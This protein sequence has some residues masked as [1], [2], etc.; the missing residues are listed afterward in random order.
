MASQKEKFEIESNKEISRIKA[1]TSNEVAKFK[2]LADEK[3]NELKGFS[4]REKNYQVQLQKASAQIAGLNEQLIVKTKSADIAESQLKEHKDA[5]KQAQSQILNLNQKITEIQAHASEKIIES[6]TELENKTKEYADTIIKIKTDAMESLARQKEE[7]DSKSAAEISELKAGF[8]QE[9]K[10]YE[11][12]LEESEKTL[13]TEQNQKLELELKFKAA[14][15]K[16]SHFEK[17]LNTQAQSLT[18]LGNKYE[19]ERQLR[20]DTEHKLSQY[21]AEI[22]VQQERA[23]SEAKAKTE[24]QEN[25]QKLETEFETFKG[26]SEKTIET[27]KSEL[28]KSQ[29]EFESESKI[30]QMLNVQLQNE[31]KAKL[32]ADEELKKL[33]VQLNELKVNSANEISSIKTQAAE[34]T[35]KIKTELEEKSNAY[36]DSVIKANADA[37]QLLL[38]EKEKWENQTDSK[39]EQVKNQAYEDIDKIKADFENKANEYNSLIKEAEIKLIAETQSAQKPK[40]NCVILTPK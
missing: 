37:Q 28:D 4:E 24:I 12:L 19:T 25:L 20:L 5:L 16:N 22:Q 7:L 32:Q 3:A 11:L 40:K 17:Q 1:E 33:T 35:V 29:H 36:A 39:I 31:Q 8:N 27:L 18:E 2:L 13:K 10:N 30:R 9:I 21:S 26:R 34:L 23:I 38:V 15:E 14:D 6:K